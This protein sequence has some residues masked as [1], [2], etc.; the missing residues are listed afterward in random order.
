[1]DGDLLYAV[2]Q[3]G[4]AVCLETA[5]GKERW[6]KEYVKYFGGQ[7]PEWGYTGMPLVDGQQVILTPGGPRGNLVALNKTTGK[8]VWQ[9]RSR[10]GGNRQSPGT[11]SEL[12]EPVLEADAGYL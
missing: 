6:R 2:G 8:L 10:A 3:Y 4:E 7:L 1:V 12:G 9:S 5:T 11:S